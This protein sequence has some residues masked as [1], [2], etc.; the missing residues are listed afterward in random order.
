MS[1]PDYNFTP[2]EAAYLANLCLAV[3]A[4]SQAAAGLS[5]ALDEGAMMARA[6][7]VARRGVSVRTINKAIK[8]NIFAPHRI[9]TDRRRRYVSD[10][11]VA[12][13][14]RRC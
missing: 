12:Y 2:S 5:V 14:H 8:E 4:T 13:A 10:A 1:L 9:R 11:A 3:T 6:P 7:S